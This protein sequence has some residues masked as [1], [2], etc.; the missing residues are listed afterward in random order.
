[1]LKQLA[2]E[3]SKMAPSEE[4]PMLV[5]VCDFKERKT[6]QQEKFYHAMLGE[7]AEQIE[8]EGRKF[9]APVW[10][11]YFVRKYVGTKEVILPD[12]EIIQERKSTVDLTVEEY[13]ELI[14]KTSAE[15]ATEYGWSPAEAQAA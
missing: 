1:M 8:V 4:H 15:L 12:G 10:K 2:V 13:A 11:A 9:S 7:A 5:E 6:R 3:L 14:D